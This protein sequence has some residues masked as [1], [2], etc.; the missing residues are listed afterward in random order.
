MATTNK[1]AFA[2]G[3]EVSVEGTVSIGK[4]NLIEKQQDNGKISSYNDITITGQDTVN[5]FDVT[6]KNLTQNK[7]L[8]QFYTVKQTKVEK[9]EE[10]KQWV[11]KEFPVMGQADQPVL[12]N[13]ERVE[14]QVGDVITLPNGKT[15]TVQNTITDSGEKLTY[16]CIGPSIHSKMT[17][18]LW[19]GSEPSLET[20]QSGTT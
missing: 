20:R 11:E 15:A 17:R 10:V 12:I 13:G 2:N 5:G 16:G 4:M 6:F 1:E 14:A 19:P 9:E 18:R 3:G 7:D 8:A